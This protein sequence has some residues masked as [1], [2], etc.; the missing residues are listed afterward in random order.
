MDY[1]N[2]VIRPVTKEGATVNTLADGRQED[3]GEN[4]DVEGD[5]EDDPGSNAHLNGPTDVVVS[6]NGDIFVSDHENHAI[7]VITPQ[8]A[9]RTGRQCLQTRRGRTRASTTHTVSHWTRRRTYWWPISATT[10]LASTDPRILPR[11]GRRHRSRR[12]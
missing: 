3:D 12:P 6:V 2:H 5:F 11:R 4:D 8:V 10:R 7:R 1:G 9:V